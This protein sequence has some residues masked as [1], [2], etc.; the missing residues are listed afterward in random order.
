MGDWV[1]LLRKN[2][3][4]KRCLLW[5]KLIAIFCILG[6]PHRR[7]KA[8]SWEQVMRVHTRTRKRE[9]HG[10]LPPRLAPLRTLFVT[11]LS[12]FTLENSAKII[13]LPPTPQCTRIW[14]R[15]MIGLLKKPL[16]ICQSGCRLKG[17]S[18]RTVIRW[19]R[20]RPRTR[21]SA[22]P[23]RRY[24]PV[25]KLRLRRR[26]LACMTISFSRLTP[27]IWT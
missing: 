13:V 21:I 23:R 15:A 14:V 18:K 27:G 19:V 7:R 22:L 1:I 9:R 16:S 17:N 6:V 5:S 26:L 24:Q 25:V 2:F 12:V 3:F 8:E 10:Q 20:W 4:S 11:H